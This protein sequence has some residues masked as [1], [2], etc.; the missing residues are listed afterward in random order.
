MPY[1]FRSVDARGYDMEYA[2]GRVRDMEY[3]LGRVGY[4]ICGI[5]GADR[6]R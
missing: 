4:G 1:A 5:E 6:P 3:A 2:L